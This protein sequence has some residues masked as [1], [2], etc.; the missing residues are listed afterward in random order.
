MTTPIGCCRLF[1]QNRTLANVPRHHRCRARQVHS[2]S[3][4]DRQQKRLSSILYHHCLR[5]HFFWRRLFRGLC[6]R[7]HGVVA[8]NGLIGTGLLQVHHV[9]QG[10][11]YEEFCTGLL[12]IRTSFLSEEA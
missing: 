8:Q 3:Q 5:S 2:A 12:A 9:L 4:A 6:S 1:V 10:P 11:L 7:L